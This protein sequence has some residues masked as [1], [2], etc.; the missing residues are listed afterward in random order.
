MRVYDRIV[1][2]LGGVG[3][4]ALWQLARRGVRVLGIDQ[5]TASHDRGSSHGQ[6]RIIRQAYFEHP[7]YVPL[8]L[9]AYQLWDQ[10]EHL[11]QEQL[12]FRVG[13]IE[14]GPPDGVVLPGVER[15]VAE[16]GLQL[17]RPTP[18]ALGRRYPQF[19]I[20]AGMEAV[21]EP[22]AGFLRVE[23]CVA[24]HLALAERAGSTIRWQ[25]PVTGLE[26]DEKG[27]TVHAA[28]ESFRADGVV[29]C[30]GAWA[31]ALLP[32]LPPM[33]VLRKHLHWYAAERR[34][35]H[36]DAGCP[37]FFFEMPQGY[38][39][40]F[41]AIDSRGV[42]LAEH[43]GGEVVVD[44]SSVSRRT[45]PVDARRV[46]DFAAECLPSLAGPPTDHAVC[47]YTM[48]PDEHFLVDLHPDCRRVAIAAGFSGH[49]FKFASVLGEILA[50]L[51]LD[52]QTQWPIDP[53]RLA[54]LKW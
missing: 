7:L 6:T 38:F 12:F 10:L 30:P 52:G 17:E 47:M 1:L 49:G 45:D 31:P 53:L 43:S 2:G 48:T 25:T 8:L 9:R 18:A 16:H 24:A 40:G 34:P 15:S 26:W 32:G 51:S 14:V 11:V 23:R 46:R 20:P 37:V 28:T 3:S 54:R 35:W 13:L 22:T 27:V 42:K 19:H 50:E 4:A 21:I 36:V 41:P 33:R 39:Y 5:F 44:P 29:C